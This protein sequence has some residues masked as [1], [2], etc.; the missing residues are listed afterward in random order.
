MIIL[1]TIIFIIYY[2]WDT[3]R[4]NIFL[5]LTV[6][7]GIL[8]P[9]C[10]WY[11]I[12][13]FSHDGFGVSIYQD[14]KKEYGKKIVPMNML[15]Y[16]INVVLDN[17]FIQQILDKSPNVFGVGKL[18]FDFFK[19][20]MEYNVGVSQGCP[21]KKRRKFNEAVLMSDMNHKMDPDFDKY[22]QNQLQDSLPEEFNDFLNFGKRLA[23][24][25][26]FND[27]YVYEPIFQ[28]FQAANSASS[29]MFGTAHIDSDLKQKYFDFM[30][31]SLKNPNKGS[32]IYMINDADGLDET[33]ILH[34][35]PHWIF[36]ITGLIA[37]S[38]L[39]FLTI[40]A[41]CQPVLDKLVKSN[42]DDKYMRQCILEFLRLSNPVNS[43]FRTLLED[44][45]FNNEYKF[46][47]GDQFL[48]INNPIMRD[49]NNFQHPTSYEPE[50]WNDPELENKYY[51]LMF[52]QGPQR[53]PGKELAIFLLGSFI[54]NYLKLTTGKIYTNIRIDCQDI[55]QSINPCTIKISH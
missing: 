26:V 51:S 34:Q 5:L 17:S 23:M 13:D 6:K 19:S 41:N 33:E 18:K 24:R 37:I 38:A 52:N 29:V 21:W 54:K 25:V 39:R 2:N 43:T 9:D 53:C 31:S 22:I 7:R 12:S 27:D 14:I 35:I 11:G 45:N 47:K 32:L 40:L 44:Y 8:A 1:I 36:P 55:P 30:K 49:P 48:I 3:I 16:Q 42:Y 20:F 28:M 4:T 50:R 10:F 46:K 15:G